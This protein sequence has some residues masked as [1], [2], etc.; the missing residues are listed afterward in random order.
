M[1]DTVFI[2]LALFRVWLE[3]SSNNEAGPVVE[4]GVADLGDGVN[5]DASGAGR[6]VYDGP[7]KKADI[8]VSFNVNLSSADGKGE[9]ER[10]KVLAWWGKTVESFSIVDFGLFGDS[11]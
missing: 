9:E 1:A 11:E 10:E 4:G 8:V 6:G 3:R 5:G 2:G 7:K